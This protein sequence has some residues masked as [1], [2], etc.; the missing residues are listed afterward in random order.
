M[1]ELAQDPLELHMQLKQL[2]AK[3]RCRWTINDYYVQYKALEELEILRLNREPGTNRRRIPF[4]VPPNP[5]KTECPS[6]QGD[7]VLTGCV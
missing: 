4:E 2:V 7:R 6:G 5:T 1:A 3:P